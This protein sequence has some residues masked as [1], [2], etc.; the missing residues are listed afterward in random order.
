MKISVASS[1]EDPSILTGSIIYVE[2]NSNSP[3]NVIISSGNI[4]CFYFLLECYI[5]EK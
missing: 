4:P 3:L 5:C 2:T 1:C